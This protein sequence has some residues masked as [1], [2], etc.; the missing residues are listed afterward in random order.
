[1]LRGK[2]P[3]QGDQILPYRRRIIRMR[4][5]GGVDKRIFLRQPHRR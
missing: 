1:M 5:N 4:T 2:L 3:V